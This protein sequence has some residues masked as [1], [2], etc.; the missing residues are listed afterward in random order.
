VS[1]PGGRVFSARTVGACRF[2]E[3]CFGSGFAHGT[4]MTDAIQAE[5]QGKFY[6][7]NA[8]ADA[9]LRKLEALGWIKSAGFRRTDPKTAK[10]VRFGLGKG[11]LSTYPHAH[12]WEPV[13]D[14]EAAVR[15]Y[16]G[17]HTPAMCF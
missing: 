4:D 14:F 1:A 10:L 12:G 9:E 5:A 11:D 17:E 15:A 8:D 3:T 6:T 2:L 7:D 16:V 13:R